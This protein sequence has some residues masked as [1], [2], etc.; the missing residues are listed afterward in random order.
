MPGRY[1]MCRLTTSQSIVYKYTAVEISLKEHTENLFNFI[2]AYSGEIG[3]EHTHTHTHRHKH[4]H[5]HTHRMTYPDVAL[6]RGAD[7]P[8][9]VDAQGPLGLVLGDRAHG[10]GLVR[11]RHVAGEVTH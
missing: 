6:V 11:T 4:T 8:L 2:Q 5:T 3:T 10:R 1:F 9:G 7:A